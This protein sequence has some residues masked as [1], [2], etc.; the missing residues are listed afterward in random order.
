MV[1][2]WLLLAGGLT[3]D[4]Q[5]PAIQDPNAPLMLGRRVQAKPSRLAKLPSAT[6]EVEAAPEKE[7]E[8]LRSYARWM[9][10]ALRGAAL[11]GEANT[12]T[13]QMLAEFMSQDP[14]KPKP[15]TLPAFWY[16]ALSVGPSLS[17]G[18]SGP[19][20]MAP[21]PRRR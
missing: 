17:A 11:K 18:S 8:A 6:V 15:P 10:P 9:A 7:S 16:N 5:G 21:Y 14:S 2:A 4:G 19:P 13:S 3:V 12:G 1:W 20:F